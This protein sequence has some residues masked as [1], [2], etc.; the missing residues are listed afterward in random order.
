[1]NR[2]QFIT[3]AAA[4]S[5]MA[6]APSLLRAQTKKSPGNKY[7][8]CAFEKPL[9]F[10]SYDELA[11]LLAE[12][13]YDGIEATVRPG[14]HVLPEKVEED[15]PRLHEALRKRGLNISILTSGI[16]SVDSPHAEK[17]LRTASKLGLKR[18][19]MLWYQYDLKKPILPQL[20]TFRSHLDKLA[21]LN[22]Q[23]GVTALYQNHAGEKYVGAPLWDIYSLVKEFDPKEVSIAYDIRHATVEGG[24][25]WPIQFQ[26]IQ[27]HLGAVFIKD[28]T[29]ENGKLKNTPLGTGMVNP[30]F[31]TM[32][33]ESNFSGPVSVHVEYLGSS[34]D[35][36]VIGD[37]FRKDLKTLRQLLS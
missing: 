32:L 25:S 4:L 13:G 11:E 30:K 31:F 33:K 1:M 3:S 6:A 14:G 20:D 35:K 18:Y 7:E 36:Q 37:A 17:V 12:L 2:R 24:L 26:L 16:S 34:K 9:Q 23:H 28:C 19:R 5:A 10:L 27:S 29:W 21:A 22:R 15:L 8:F